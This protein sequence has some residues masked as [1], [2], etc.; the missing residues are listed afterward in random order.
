LAKRGKRFHVPPH[1]LE[2]QDRYVT[3][4]GDVAAVAI[5]EEED[6]RKIDHVWITVRAGEFGACRSR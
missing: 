6:E 4:A 5:E 1:L 2:L 3:V